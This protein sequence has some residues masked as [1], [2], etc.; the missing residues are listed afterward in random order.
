[1]K[2]LFSLLLLLI[3][4]VAS[5]QAQL[6]YRISGNG[7]KMPSYIVGTHHFTPASFADSI[8]GVQRALSE[9]QQ[10]YGELVLQDM[11]SS[12]NL[13]KMAQAMLLPQDVT[14]T[15][16]LT[17][18]ETAR[19]N[20]A[21][22]ELMGVDLNTPGMGAQLNK[23][24]PAA[25]SAQFTQ[26]LYSKHHPDVNVQEQFD[27]YFQNKA[28]EQCKGVFAL[29]TM[30]VQTKALFNSQ[31]LE[32]QKEML[33]CMV[34]HLDFEL[35]M[36]EEMT[37]AFRHQDLEALATA[38]DKKLGGSCD[39]TPEEEACLIYDRN[40]NW[41]EKMP[42]IMQSKPTLFAVGAAHLIGE[43]GVLQLLRNDGY[44]VEGVK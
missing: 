24:L 5:M 14:L 6:L 44:T 10:V 16:L 22:K 21:L 8:P 13:M 37:A 36:L 11:M 20:V 4:A 27:G 19:L 38:T 43:K 33:M 12:E 35:Q 9:T 28:L 29:E 1:M 32:R 31:S 34:D 25:L 39:S 30:D 23:M 18:D 40:A 15:S 26:I 7:L 42:A 41:F 17:D 2:R 3:V